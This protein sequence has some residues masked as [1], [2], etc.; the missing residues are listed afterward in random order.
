MTRLKLLFCSQCP[1]SVPSSAETYLT[2][3]ITDN[4]PLQQ[5]NLHD[6]ESDNDNTDSS[7]VITE[8]NHKVDIDRNQLKRLCEVPDSSESSHA[9]IAYYLNVFDEPANQE[10]DGR[11]VTKLLRDYEK[12]EGCR[13]YDAEYS[14]E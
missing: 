7:H 5:M 12:K 3:D 13:V 1:E 9:L 11:H 10:E 6:P 8:D 4:M 2:G 14:T